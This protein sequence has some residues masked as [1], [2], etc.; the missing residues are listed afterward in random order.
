LK[1]S[2]NLTKLW[3]NVPNRDTSPPE[4]A[5]SLKIVIDSDEIP[6]KFDMVFAFVSFSL[7]LDSDL[8]ILELDYG[9]EDSENLGQLS[10][11]VVW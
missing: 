5:I 6:D 1:D 7:Y 2:E 3:L 10:M 8:N 9:L 4:L 11:F